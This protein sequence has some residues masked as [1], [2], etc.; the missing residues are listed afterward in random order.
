[1]HTALPYT[2][3]PRLHWGECFGKQM[4]E[5]KEVQVPLVEVPWQHG[6]GVPQIPANKGSC[7]GDYESPPKPWQQL[8]KWELHPSCSG[9]LLTSAFWGGPSGVVSRLL[10]PMASLLGGCECCRT[11]LKAPRDL[12]NV[13]SHLG[14]SPA[15]LLGVF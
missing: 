4:K 2:R 8:F 9:A 10:A 3:A 15:Q 14:P 12:S 6:E 5:Q 13:T 11:H 1:M 7:L